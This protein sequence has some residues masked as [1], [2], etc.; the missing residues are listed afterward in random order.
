MT[1]AI[2]P[3]TGGG[4]LFD[5]RSM[6]AARQSEPK[7]APGN[8]PL[9]REYLAY[10]RVEKGLRPLSCE[11]YE[12]DLLQFAE[13][14]E[15]QAATLLN[16]TQKGIAGF[17][18]HLAKAQCRIALGRAQALLPARFLSLAPAG[19]AHPPRPNAESGVAGHLEGSA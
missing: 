11:A 16:A 1:A 8:S 17:L 18:K 12:R 3:L 4:I 5:N 14:L 13:Y 6:G 7:P 19:Q 15:D 10:L 9:L 2:P